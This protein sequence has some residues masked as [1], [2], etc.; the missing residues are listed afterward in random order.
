M[1]Q[2]K[3]SI[4]LALV[5]ILFLALLFLPVYSVTITIEN[6]SLVSYRSLAK[7]PL[8]SI[9]VALISCISIVSIFMFKNRKS[10]IKVVNAGLLL[11]LVLFVLGISFT[12]LF[13]NASVITNGIPIV[14]YSMGIYLI[15]LF[16]ALFFFAAR[17]IKKDEELVKAADRLR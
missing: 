15:G 3:Q 9:G 11:S 8:L 6:Q 1:I 5:P 2:R 16:P 14:G 17:F 12:N 4:F 13:S 7:L 10:Q